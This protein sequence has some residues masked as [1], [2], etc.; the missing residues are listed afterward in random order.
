[1]EG[2]SQMPNSMITTVLEIEQEAESILSLAEKE[3]AKIVADAREDRERAAKEAKESVSRQI[4]TLEADVLKNR[5]S[6]IRDLTATGETALA[7]VKNVPIAAVNE[8]VE[9]ILS[10]LVG[11]K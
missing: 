8:G 5:E 9:Y 10:S 1:M 2:K 11:R 3:A 7:V 4:S 6:I